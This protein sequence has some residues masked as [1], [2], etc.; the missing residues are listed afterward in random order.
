[1][2]YFN[3]YQKGELKQFFTKFDQIQKFSQKN[4]N[5]FLREFQKI[6]ND[7]ENESKKFHKQKLLKKLLKEH[8]EMTQ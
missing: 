7:L 6:R 5:S 4:S 1:M 3:Q 2:N 8:F